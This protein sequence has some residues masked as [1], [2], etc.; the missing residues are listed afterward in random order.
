MITLII[1][2]FFFLTCEQLGA[3]TNE[4]REK[5]KVVTSSE[6]IATAKKRKTT[7]SKI[8]I[9]EKQKE[10]NERNEIIKLVTDN[11]LKL[12]STMHLISPLDL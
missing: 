2:A 12:V 8:D 9:F 1:Y 4:K 3:I 11:R 6:K 10:N 7:N 5:R